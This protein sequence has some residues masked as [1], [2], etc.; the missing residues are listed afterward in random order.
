MVE[1][2]SLVLCPDTQLAVLA[3]RSE[4]STYATEQLPSGTKNTS[5]GEGILLPYEE[6]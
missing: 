5:G 2:D 4:E 6:A 1:Q 3:C